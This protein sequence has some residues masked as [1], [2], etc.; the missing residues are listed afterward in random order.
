MYFEQLPELGV[1]C[2]P[3]EA[4]EPNE[5]HV[6]R[7]LRGNPPTINDFYSQVKLG[8]I[9]TEGRDDDFVCRAHACSINT[10]LDA[11]RGLTKLPKF[12]QHAAVAALTLSANCGR[13]LKGNGSHCDWWIYAACTPLNLITDVLPAKV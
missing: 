8:T 12:K 5:L 13:I 10:S 6:Y 9:K 4:F 1:Q 7:L 11:A 3:A 2:P